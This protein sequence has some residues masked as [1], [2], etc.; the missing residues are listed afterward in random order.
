MEK[1]AF[2]RGVTAEGIGM[3]QNKS[4]GSGGIVGRMLGG[5]GGWANRGERRLRGEEAT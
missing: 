1:I 2:R 3:N 4:V 5:A